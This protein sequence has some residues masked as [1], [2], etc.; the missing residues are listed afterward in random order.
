MRNDVAQFF[1]RVDGD[2]GERDR[3]CRFHR[4]RDLEQIIRRKFERQALVT[5]ANGATARATPAEYSAGLRLAIER[6]W[7][8]DAWER[9]FA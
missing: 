1:A 4:H 9:L 7:M 5:R 2:T 6:G 8:R 3:L